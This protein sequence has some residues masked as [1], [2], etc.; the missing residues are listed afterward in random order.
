MSS[1][2]NPQTSSALSAVHP[3]NHIVLAK[4]SLY[5]AWSVEHAEFNLC[6]VGIS[7]SWSL[8]GDSVG[9]SQGD[10]SRLMHPSSAN[11]IK[12]PRQDHGRGPGRVGRG[13]V[14]RVLG[15]R[16]VG[17]HVSQQFDFSTLSYT[18]DVNLFP[19]LH[20]TS[21]TSRRHGNTLLLSC[22]KV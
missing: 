6:S 20:A 7:I 21:L 1:K 8:G 16:D 2:P 17:L 5:G 14:V 13:R 9:V 11:W 10:N 18:F 19:P 3:Y 4:P 22:S 15:T 12:L